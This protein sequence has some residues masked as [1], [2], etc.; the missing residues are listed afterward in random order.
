VITP[1]ASI[2]NVQR[3]APAGSHGEIRKRVIATMIGALSQIVPDKVAGD[4]CRTSFHNLI[5]GFDAA[6]GREWVH[7][8]WSAG[9]NGAFKEDDGPS[10]MASIDWGDLVTV[11]STEVIETRM[12][13]LVESSRLCTDS[14]GAGMSRGGLSMQRALRVMVPGARYSLLSDGALLPAFGVL[15]GRSGVPVGSWIDRHSR[16]EEFDTPG[17][18][19][20]H[21]VEQDARVV[22]RSA[23]GGGYGDPLE[24]D[25]E[26]VAFDVR[27]EYVSPEAAADMYGVL[28]QSS[29]E[30]DSAATLRRRKHLRASRRTLSAVLD[31]KIFEPGAVSQRRI[32]RL[33]P[34]DAKAFGGT[35]DAIVELDAGN[36]APL[37]AWLR[38]D[39]SVPA[40]TV[41]MDARGLAILQI[42]PQDAVQV[43]RLLNRTN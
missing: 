26:R 35:E 5:G 20:G 32:C 9:G 16:I 15:G 42:K 13:L 41:P 33:N 39:A 37:R 43:R 27:E 38:V 1:P 22:I 3:P 18:V 21:A 34:V 23:G 4:L 11:Q 12:P 6:S 25:P 31:D 30:L 17:K 28:L 14:G 24:R 2:V 10:A 36:A 7:Y 40:G 19:A 29:G 8:E